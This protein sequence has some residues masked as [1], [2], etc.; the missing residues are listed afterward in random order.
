[1]LNRL[2][3][4]FTKGFCVLLETKVLEFSWP[5]FHLGINNQWRFGGIFHPEISMSFCDWTRCRCKPF[6]KDIQFKGTMA[7]HDQSQPAPNDTFQVAVLRL[8]RYLTILVEKLDSGWLG[9]ACF[10]RYF[11]IIFILLIR[12]CVMTSTRLLNDV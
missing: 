7:D 8:S 2:L 1:M 9:F 6:L 3:N 4:G 12:E 5:W 11:L 10:F